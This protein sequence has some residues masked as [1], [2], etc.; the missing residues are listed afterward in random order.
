MAA[1]IASASRIGWKFCSPTIARDDEGRLVDCVLDSPAAIA[2][3]VRASVR[4]WRLARI[5]A[6]FPELIPSAPDWEPVSGLQHAQVSTL[7][8]SGVIDFAHI[9]GKLVQCRTASIAGLEQWHAKCAPY[10]MSQLCGGQWPQARFAATRSWTDDSRCQLCLEATGTLE[11]RAHCP[12][13]M[14]IGGW[15]ELP[16]QARKAVSRMSGARLKLASTRG[17][18]AIRVAVPPGLLN[19]QFTWLRAPPD[20]IPDEAIWYIDGSMM[21]GRWVP[22]RR[23]GFGI[24]VIGNDGSLL[25]F[26]NGNP[27]PWVT[28]AAGAE[29]WALSVI[30]GMCPSLP[31][32]VTDCKGVRDVL[33]AGR[34]SATAHTRP[35]ARIWKTI[36]H[37]LDD[38]DDPER[39]GR[40]LVWMPAHGATH[41]IGKVTKSNG[42]AI[43]S[44]DWRAN[45]LVDALAKLAV[46]CHQVPDSAAQLLEA[47]AKAVE[48]FAGI[49]GITAFAANHYEKEIERPDGSIGKVTCRDAAPQDGWKAKRKS[50][51]SM[52]T[53][54]TPVAEASEGR[55]KSSGLPALVH[56]TQSDVSFH[57]WWRKGLGKRLAASSSVAPPACERL[58]ALRRR[59]ADRE[60]IA[61]SSCQPSLNAQFSSIASP[62]HCSAASVDWAS[63]VPDHPAQRPTLNAL[64]RGTYRS[65]SPP[66]RV[67]RC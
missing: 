2:A 59:V 23:T 16:A 66:V 7:L 33:C 42:S 24:A 50:R 52:V 44:I 55:G 15:P 45:R 41:T 25:G 27:P 35:L 12:A 48:H 21:G 57:T 43:T 26:G 1:M 36:F 51:S 30:V 61:R 64:F 18:M 4:R 67:A 5:F 3:L 56:T 63:R 60:A 40:R 46:A 38:L 37:A 9:I 28:S 49:V 62:A 32:V 10:L 17:L 11:H 19:A 20:V 47:G 14:P 29:A 58:E 53:S 54:V 31:C 6:N 39:Y 13:T 34:A 8:P 65:R 22:L